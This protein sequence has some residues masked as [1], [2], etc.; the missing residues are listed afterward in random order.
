MPSRWKALGMEAQPAEGRKCNKLM[1]MAPMPS[2][3]KA[4][5]M[6]AQPAEGRKCKKFVGMAPMPSLKNRRLLY[7]FS[8]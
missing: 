8:G 6:G 5:G 4:L 2:R 3:W 7:A 1:V